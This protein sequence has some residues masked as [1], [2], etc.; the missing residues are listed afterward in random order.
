MTPQSGAQEV[1]IEADAGN[2]GLA[3]NGRPASGAAAAWHVDSIEADA[4]LADLFAQFSHLATVAADDA[5][6][7]VI[8]EAL[9]VIAP[10]GRSGDHGDWLHKE[11]RIRQMIDLGACVSAAMELLPIGATYTLAIRSPQQAEATVT[12]NNRTAS[13]TVCAR[14]AATALVAALFRA[15]AIRLSST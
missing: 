15:L 10:W 5:E 3:G 2:G 7:S 13:G 14:T 12:L 9:I 4:E 11:A 1:P 6:R 8:R